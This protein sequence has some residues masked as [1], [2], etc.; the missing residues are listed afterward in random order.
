MKVHHKIFEPYINQADIERRVRELAEQIS[1]D[2][3]DENPL[4]LAVL[5]GSF[6]FTSDILKLLEFPAEV[7]FIK[8]ASYLGTESSGNVSELIGLNENIEGRD[9]VILEDIVDSG[10]TIEKLQAMLIEKGAKNVTIASFLYKPSKYKASVP[11]DYV[12]F[13]IPDYFVIGY[14][15]DYNGYGRNIKEIYKLKG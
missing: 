10:L 1:A 12:G 13:D 11:L 2:H 14:G 15:M 7:S 5:N 8:I 4:F 6:M 3:K 9:I